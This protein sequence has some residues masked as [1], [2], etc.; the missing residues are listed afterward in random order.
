MYIIKTLKLPYNN[1]FESYE[2]LAS[3][4]NNLKKFSARRDFNFLKVGHL[5]KIT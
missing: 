2:I 3:I 4:N 5:K 1:F